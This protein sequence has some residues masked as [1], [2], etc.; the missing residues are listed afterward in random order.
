ML[1]TRENPSLLQVVALCA[2]CLIMAVAIGCRERFNEA[3]SKK[4][5]E[6]Q[7]ATDADNRSPVSLRISPQGAQRRDHVV[8]L[9]EV[10][11]VSS[12]PLAWDREWSIFLQWRVLYDDANTLTSPDTVDS[13]MTQTKESL[14]RKRFLVIK[15][16]GACEKE[17]TLTEPFRRFRIDPISIEGQ[18]HPTMFRGYEEMVKYVIPKSVRRMRVQMEYD[19]FRQVGA[20]RDLF[21]FRWDEVGLPGWDAKSNE[22][23]IRFDDSTK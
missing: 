18:K 6:D 22:V 15:P 10:R 2:L 20:F 7:K 16:G 21:G 3:S 8:L 19:T 11:N 13:R 1:R 23:V 17:C 4:D 12:R 9:V 14:D 5:D